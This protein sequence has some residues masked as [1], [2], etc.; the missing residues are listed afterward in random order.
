MQHN[1]EFLQALFDGIQATIARMRVEDKFNQYRYKTYQWLVRGSETEGSR[2]QNQIFPIEQISWDQGSYT[3]TRYK[4]SYYIF[5]N[6]NIEY[7]DYTHCKIDLVVDFYHANKNGIP[8]LEVCLNINWYTHYQFDWKSFVFEGKSIRDILQRFEDTLLEIPPIE[9][10]RERNSIIIR[11]MPMPPEKIDVL[12][13]RLKQYH[14]D[15]LQ[16]Q[17]AIGMMNHK[18]L[19]EALRAYDLSSDI[20]SL[21]SRMDISSMETWPDFTE[22]VESEMH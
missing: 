10:H 11:I 4:F 18:R 20:L 21:I 2:F 6:R 16:R 1:L 3:S 5:C 14:Q 8:D 13:N 22:S 7:L 15:K 12:Y 17:V 9:L 19:G